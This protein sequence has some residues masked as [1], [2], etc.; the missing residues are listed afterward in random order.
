VSIKNRAGSCGCCQG[1]IIFD[2]DPNEQTTE[3]TAAEI[4]KYTAS[5]GL[6][7]EDHNGFQ[8]KI[9]IAAGAVITSDLLLPLDYFYVSFAGIDS[10]WSEFDWPPIEHPFLVE[11]FPEP[12]GYYAEDG[13]RISYK[14]EYDFT[15]YG[16]DPIDP[17]IPLRYR[18]TL[19]SKTTPLQLGS[20]DIVARGRAIVVQ[21]PTICIF[22]DTAEVFGARVQPTANG[23]SFVPSLTDTSLIQGSDG[24]VY[25]QSLT[26]QRYE[27]V[28]MTMRIT[29]LSSDTPLEL[30]R[31]VAGRI[32]QGLS[33]RCVAVPKR[34]QTYILNAPIAISSDLGTPNPVAAP[35]IAGHEPLS[36]ASVFYGVFIDPTTG[37]PTGSN[38]EIVAPAYDVDTVTSTVASPNPG[39]VNRRTEQ[40]FYFTAF[41]QF[42]DIHKEHQVQINPLYR[43]GG[44]VGLE[45]Q[46]SIGFQTTT[47]TSAAS[48]T[49]AL[50]TYTDSIDPTDFTSPPPW[51]DGTVTTT[52]AIQ[53]VIFT[54]WGG[55]GWGLAKTTVTRTFVVEIDEWGVGAF[56]GFTLHCRATEGATIA[57]VKHVS[58]PDV[59]TEIADAVVEIEFWR[60][61]TERGSIFTREAVFPDTIE[62]INAGDFYD[63]P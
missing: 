27:N 44:K 14:H 55:L 25:L 60:S 28:R 20:P 62:I 4:A 33:P 56:P 41:T 61:T 53:N 35:R 23:Q 21:P 36:L 11:F 16:A 13:V 39:F 40:Y 22:D 8:K 2:I 31:I 48:V 6:T 24:T 58:V 37:E 15:G 5:S 51:T 46:V 59:D 42:E 10:F 9:R 43:T 3:E 49:E 7:I 19:F 12:G 63:E 26:R 54:G 38:P 32:G 30:Y 52:V 29:N 45:L 1:C 50:T 47:G 17:T 18:T 57:G 34:N